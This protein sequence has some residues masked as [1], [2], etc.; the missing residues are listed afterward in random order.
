MRPCSVLYLPPPTFRG[1]DTGVMVDNLK[2][3]P[4][5]HPML[6]YSDH[7]W[8][9][10]GLIKLGSSPE[11]VKDAKDAKGVPNKWAVNNL[12]WATGMRIAIKNEFSHVLYLEADCR[13]GCPGWD[14]KIFDEFFSVGRALACAGTLVTFNPANS[15][16]IGWRK[17]NDLM[18]FNSRRNY[19]RATYGCATYGFKG[20]ADGS[21]SS[22]FPNGAL[23][24]YSMAW[25][26]ELFDFSNSAQLAA[27]MFAWD[28]AIGDRLW[29]KMD[30]Q[31]YECVAHLNSVYS[32][33]GDVITGESE[34]LSLLRSGKVC[35]IH[36][37]KS[38][39]TF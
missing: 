23:G 36:Q 28:F 21:G 33:Y 31:A 12:I 8:P 37:C 17:W 34:R 18:A 1:C 24:V 16:P 35:A 3:F 26:Q 38:S 39:A 19:E 27:E 2:K 6:V 29:K 13:V 4:P 30:H 5:K 7:P 15:G 25:M 9:V 20:A 10:D 32:S 22:I 11:I 14:D